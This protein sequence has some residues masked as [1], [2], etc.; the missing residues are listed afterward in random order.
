MATMR[1]SAETICGWHTWTGTDG[2][3]HARRPR[4]SP[5]VG[6]RAKIHADGE[7]E[8]SDTE[9]AKRIAQAAQD[10]ANQIAQ[11]EQDIADRT[12]WPKALAAR[13]TD[14]RTWQQRRWDRMRGVLTPGPGF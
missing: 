4:T 5:P 11:A 9:F 13:E 12:F 6:V 2:H 8:L 3:L 14:L 7:D 1:A 10:L